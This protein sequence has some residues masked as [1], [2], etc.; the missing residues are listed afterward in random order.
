VAWCE[1]WNIEINEDKTWAIY[2]PHWI[3]PPESPLTLNGWNIPFVNSVKYLGVIFYKRI[4]WRPHTEMIKS[5]AFTTLIIVYALFKS[6]RL[7]NNIKLTLHRALIR[8]VMTQAC[9]VWEIA[10]DTHLINPSAWF[11]VTVIS[12]HLNR[13]LWFVVTPTSDC[14][15]NFKRP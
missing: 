1:Y 9:S 6:E 12:R 5:K 2:L 10:A 7:S 4:T 11:A 13:L 15:H 14:R 3:T 8:S